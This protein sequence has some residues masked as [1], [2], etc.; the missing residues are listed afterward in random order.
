MSYMNETDNSKR[1]ISFGLVLL[2]HFGIFYLLYTETGKQIMQQVAP[3]VIVEIIE[4]VKPKDEPPPPPPPDMPKPEV[5]IPPP[6]IDI[7]TL[8]PPPPDTTMT[9]TREAPPPQPTVVPP[10][11][12]RQVVRTPPSADPRAARRGD[13]QPEYPPAAQRQ[14]LEGSLTLNICIGTDGRAESASVVRSSGHAILDE[15]AVK[16]F[17][18]RRPKFTPAME[19]G[20]PVR[21]CLTAPIRFQIPKN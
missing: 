19:D 4:E 2:L 13:Y 15:A 20:R 1:A 5:F 9:I 11:A 8:A 7:A 21:Q 3:P 6:V 12:P 17:E 18:R 10:P 14:E 16:H